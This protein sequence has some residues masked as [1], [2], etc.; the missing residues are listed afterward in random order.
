MGWLDEVEALV[1]GVL[2]GAGLRLERTASAKRL[3]AVRLRVDDLD[4][5]SCP[6]KGAG[7]YGGGAEYVAYALGIKDPHAPME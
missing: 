2:Y 5:Q 6:I 3:G 1:A 7:P 4:V